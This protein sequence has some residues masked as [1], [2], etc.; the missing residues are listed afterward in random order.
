MSQHVFVD[1]SKARS[2]L[3]VAVAVDSSH[4]D[5]LRSSLRAMRMK[6]QTRLHFRKEQPARRRKILSELGR[7]P[8]EIT[9]L[10]S[11]AT[12]EKTARDHCIA[13]LATAVRWQ[14]S[15]TLVLEKDD[16]RE[17]ADRLTLRT[18]FRNA[19][20]PTPRH[21]L[22]PTRNEPGLWAADAIAWALQRGGT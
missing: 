13:E 5:A 18:A 11:R 10:R 19:A 6:G 22:L 8:L 21:H 1:E 17:R 14:P 7:H 9:V 2:F 12:D 4:V 3:L 20:S 16:S 15:S